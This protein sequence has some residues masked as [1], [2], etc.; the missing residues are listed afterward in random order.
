MTLAGLILLLGSSTIAVAQDAEA[1]SDPEARIAQLREMVL[2]ANYEEATQG[3]V[4][5]L[6]R[7]D[8][9]ATQRNLDTRGRQEAT[10]VGEAIK[11]L[12]VPIG[13]VL[14]SP[15]CRCVDTAM[16]VFGKAEEREELA[17]FDVLTG[18]AKEARAKQI[19]DMLNTAPEPQMNSVLITHTG[20]LLYT[21]GLQTRPE[22]IA[23]VFRPAEYGPPGYI[24]RVTPEDWSQL[25]AAAAGG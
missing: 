13:A 25:A 18:A 21:F 19:R 15:Y 9:S 1:A 11:A 14:T 7:R 5:F 6:G 3:V 17:V 4:A 2:Y 20:T 12:G 16:L 23:H 10:Q 8:L 22:G 24:G